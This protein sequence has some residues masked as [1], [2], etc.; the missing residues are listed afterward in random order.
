MI[1]ELFAGLSLVEAQYFVSS[2]RREYWLPVARK[3]LADIDSSQDWIN[4]LACLAYRK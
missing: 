1:D 2:G 3:K 4:G